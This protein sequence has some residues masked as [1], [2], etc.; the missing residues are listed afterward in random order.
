M[1][2][3]GNTMSLSAEYFTLDSSGYP[4]KRTQRIS[5]DPSVDEFVKVSEEIVERDAIG[6]TTRQHFYNAKTHEYYSTLSE[7]KA[8]NG[9]EPVVTET[10]D[11]VVVEKLTHSS[12]TEYDSAKEL[13]EYFMERPGLPKTYDTSSGKAVWNYPVN[14][15]QVDLVREEKRVEDGQTYTYRTMRLTYDTMGGPS[16][17]S[18]FILKYSA[19]GKIVDV[20]ALDPM[21][22]FAYRNEHWVCAP[23]T[24]DVRGRAAFNI[25]AMN[26]GYL[27]SEDGRGFGDV[28]TGMWERMATVLYGAL[29]DETAEGHAYLFEK[30]DGSI[31]SFE[32]KDAFEEAVEADKKMRAELAAE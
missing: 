11:K 23:V 32:S 27:M 7:V 4:A 10:A 12:E 2:V 18:S 5:I 14:R 9:F 24:T 21:P 15:E 3:T 1:D 25:S 13:F 31:V 30:L 26:K 19:T 16:G 8:D 6:G 20:C 29:T 17:D 28:Q 22:D